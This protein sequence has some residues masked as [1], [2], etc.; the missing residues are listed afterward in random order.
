L[1]ETWNDKKLVQKSW[2][3]TETAETSSSEIK[4]FYWAS[5]LSEIVKISDSTTYSTKLLDFY[6]NKSWSSEVATNVSKAIVALFDWK[7]W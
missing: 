6:I 5:I 1:K 2:W 3:K 4:K 7:D